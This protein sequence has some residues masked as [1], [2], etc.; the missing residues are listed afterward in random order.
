MPLWAAAYLK[1]FSIRHLALSQYSSPTPLVV[2]SLVSTCR[3]GWS[4]S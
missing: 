1:K 3:T 4:C 2:V